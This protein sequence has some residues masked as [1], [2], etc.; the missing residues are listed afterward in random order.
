MLFFTWII[1]NKEIYRI[2]YLS[3]CDCKTTDQWYYWLHQDSPRVLPAWPP[4]CL[5]PVDQLLRHVTM[6][7]TVE[8]DLRYLVAQG[9]VWNQLNCLLQIKFSTPVLY[10]KSSKAP[11][12]QEKATIFLWIWRSTVSFSVTCERWGSP[13]HVAKEVI[14]ERTRKRTPKPRLAEERKKNQRSLQAFLS[15]AAHRSLGSFRVP[16]A[17]D[18]SRYPHMETSTALAGYEEL[19]GGLKV[20][21]LKIMYPIFTLCVQNCS[22]TLQVRGLQPP[23]SVD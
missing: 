13:F 21:K 2:F 9:W 7:A 12:M 14:I 16:R 15:Y 17:R 1:E 23:F 10:K 5:H 20:T 19:V 4:D 8:P 22:S 11:Q 18:Y 6:P 3:A